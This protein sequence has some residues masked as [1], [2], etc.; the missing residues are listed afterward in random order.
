[1]SQKRAKQGGEY[2]ANGE[3]YDG[4]RFMRAIQRWRAMG[5]LSQLSRN[6]PMGVC[7]G[8]LPRH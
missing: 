4:G 5:V 8:W 6:A 1:M 3:W 2:G 7:R